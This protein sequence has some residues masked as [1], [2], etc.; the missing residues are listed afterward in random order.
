M[1]KIWLIRHAESRGN[2]GE[3]TDWPHTIALTDLGQRQAVE[4]A[5]HFTVAPDLIVVS[6]YLRTVETARPTMARFP[7]SP[8]EEWPLH[9][10]TYLDTGNYRGKT[11]QDRLRPAQEYWERCQP[12][13]RDGEGAESF[14]GFM[15][16]IR[17]GIDRLR[18]SRASFTAVFTHGYVMKAIL[19]ELLFHG[20][21]SPLPF[22][23]GFREFLN[24]VPVENGMVLPILADDE[25][26]F[27]VG[28]PQ[29]AAKTQGSAEVRNRLD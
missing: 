7:N 19:W 3:K 26:Q 8:I 17:D 28:S 4:L 6:R 14:N 18:K 23:R 27:F 22:M 1:R 10:F 29:V 15:L 2:A 16:R 21:R 25:G 20:D 11:Q 9:E 5:D 12:D 13:C 24:A